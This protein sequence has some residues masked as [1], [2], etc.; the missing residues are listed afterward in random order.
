M[1]PP[2]ENRGPFAGKAEVMTDTLRNPLITLGSIPE[3]RDR[4]IS[5]MK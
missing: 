1:I 4:R 2:E 3:H 5:Q